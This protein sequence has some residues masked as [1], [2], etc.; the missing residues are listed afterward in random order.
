MT[1]EIATQI[2]NV[3]NNLTITARLSLVEDLCVTKSLIKYNYNKLFCES[4][5]T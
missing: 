3:K 2:E 4:A 1:K 5:L